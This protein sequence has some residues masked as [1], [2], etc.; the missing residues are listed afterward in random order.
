MGF[1]KRRQSSNDWK[2]GY[3]IIII[4][5]C[6][7]DLQILMLPVKAVFVCWW[8]KFRQDRSKITESEREIAQ[9]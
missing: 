8:K 9:H 2:G 4:E 7:K 5:G 3:D 1:V 6:I